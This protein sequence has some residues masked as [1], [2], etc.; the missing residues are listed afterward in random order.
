[1]PEPDVFLVVALSGRALA[2]AVRRSGRRAVVIDLFGDTDTRAHAE[3]SLVVAGDF[4]AGFDGSAVLAA[5]ECLAPAASP[6]RYGVAYSS[7]FEAQPEL[8][9]K[10]ACGRRLYGNQPETLRRTKDPESFFPALDRLGIPF[11]AVSYAMP[12]DAAG[13]L[14]KRVGGSGGGHV[15]PVSERIAAKGT[16]FQRRVAGQSLGVSFLADGHAAFILGISEQWSTPDPGS[17]SYRF[18]GILRPA[19]IAS[20]VAQDLRAVVDAIVREFG[21][22]GLNSLD[23]I[24]RGDEFFVLEVNPRP[25]ANLD[26]FDGTDPTG[27]FGLHIAACDGSLPRSWL[28]PRDSTA[29]SVLYAD[30]PLLV[31]PET[32]WPEWV[33][34]RPAPGARIEPGAP[35]CT[36]LAAGPT[37]DTVRQTI[38]ARGTE[39]FDRLRDANGSSDRSAAE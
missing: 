21:L 11:P 39:I 35:I 29:M 34:D 24:V 30:R 4:D 33:A 16:Y 18:G 26:V 38:A 23:V 19:Q 13:W 14:V 9:A 10:I 25:G 22:V 15:R 28:P 1:M 5:A 17:R 31:P 36:V 2:V 6:P 37:V 32:V 27:L 7:G 3:A 8:L 20:A 12:T